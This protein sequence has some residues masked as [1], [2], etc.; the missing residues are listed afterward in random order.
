MIRKK[1]TMRLVSE[2]LKDSKKSDRELGKILGVSQPT[3]SRERKKL[4]EEG[5]IHEYSIVPD[6]A[7]LGFEILAVSCFKTHQ[8][9]AL[10][11][12]ARKV[13]MSKPNV[14]LAAPCEGMGTNGMM[15]SLHKNYADYSNFLREIRSEGGNE[16][17][18][19]STFLVALSGVVV[20]PFSLK[21]LAELVE[22]F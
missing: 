13:T 5:I 4:G 22:K 20:K 6:F 7:K 8:I 9:G 2:L 11:E 17:E 3:V 19:V 14:V 15:I 18:S 10:T 16:V 1:L 12:K 21:Y